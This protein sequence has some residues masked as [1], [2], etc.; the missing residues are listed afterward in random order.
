MMTK[1]SRRAEHCAVGVALEPHRR[2]DSG[3][4]ADP[5]GLHLDR[6]G[7]RRQPGQAMPGQP[8]RAAAGGTGRQRERR[9]GA[10]DRGDRRRREHGRRQQRDRR[11]GSDGTAPGTATAPGDGEPAQGPATGNATGQRTAG[12]NGTARPGPTASAPHEYERHRQR[13]NGSTGSNGTRRLHR[14][15]CRSQA[16]RRGADVHLAQTIQ[17]GLQSS[18]D[19]QTAT[20]N[21]EIDR[22]RADEAAAAGPA[23]CRTPAARPFA[24]TRRPTSSSGQGRRSKSRRRIRRF[25]SSMSATGFDLTGQ[26]R[27]A[28]D[29]AR[30]QSLADQFIL[31]QIRNARILRAQTILLQHASRPASGGC[32]PGRPDQRRAAA[33][34][35]DQP[36]RRRGRAED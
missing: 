11:R 17:A 15:A 16:R 21:V 7:G 20:R 10:G 26:I 25:C 22:K 24:T 33:S 14:A 30:L 13:T 28:S 1:R 23:Q 9:D 3:R 18:A 36:E 32:R 4:R 2:A 19:V 34:G 31:G 6:P 12:N 27:A 8:E 5:A 29:Q 35:C